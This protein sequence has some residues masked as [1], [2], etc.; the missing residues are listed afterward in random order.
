[1]GALTFLQRYALAADAKDWLATSKR[2]ATKLDDAVAP[3]YARAVDLLVRPARA[4]TAFPGGATA[5][6]AANEAAASSLSQQDDGRSSPSRGH[7]RSK[8]AQQAARR[9]RQQQQQPVTTKN[10]QTA[11]RRAAGR[12]PVGHHLARD[13]ACGRLGGRAGLAFLQ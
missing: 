8:K 11:G 2:L 9:R 12:G 10:G 1:M 7:K 5:E 4:A 3:V 6:V 13:E